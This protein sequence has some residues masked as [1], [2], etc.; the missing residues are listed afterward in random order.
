MR[1]LYSTLLLLALAA[2]LTAQHDFYHQPHYHFNE[3]DTLRGMLRPERTAFDVTHYAL[4]IEVDPRR[5]YVGGRVDVTFEV[6]DATE[7]IQL[8]LYE[9]M[10]ISRILHRGRQL[11]YERVANAV[12]ID[13]GAPLEPGSTEMVQVY[14][15]GEPHV[16]KQA[17]WDGGFVWAKDDKGYPWVGVACEGDGASLWWPC[18]DHLSDEP[19]SVSLRVT[20]PKPLVY[21]GNGQ[22][23]KVEDHGT[24][25]SYNWRVTYPI[26]T[27]NVTINVGN[28]VHF[29][30]TY[31]AQDK[32]TMPMDFYVLDYN[33]KKAKKHFAQAPRSLEAFEYYFDKYPFW[34]DGYALVETPYLGMEHQSAIAYG[35]RFMRGYMGGMIPPDMDWDYIIVHETGHEWFGNSVSCGDLAEMWIHES[36]TTYMEALYV[37]YWHGYDDAL[38]YLAT[39]HAP[40]I[41]NKEPILGPKDVNWE[42]WEDSDHYF[43]GSWVL[44]T[45]RYAIGDDKLWFGILKGFYRQQAYSITTTDDF[46][47]YVN[48]ATGK[49]WAPFFEQY[50]AYVSVPQL[51][52]R[53]TGKGDQ[54]LWEYRIHADVAGFSMPLPLQV[55][56][57]PVRVEATAQWQE[58]PVKAA[59]VK[60]TKGLVLVR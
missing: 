54:R 60:M 53:A 19:D 44:H 27:Y 35:N 40:F 52:L 4:D 37:E 5:K 14:Y 9:N 12:F 32:T 41:A 10:A 28:Y 43:K 31:T 13:F 51:E 34:R 50:L 47:T 11:D 20:V 26:N 15:G 17:P 33:L 46:I 24:T 30:D 49:D 21:V 2:A 58:L 42:D 36:F 48:E 59:V 7:R 45:L 3:A 38:R 16:A 22:P 6:L 8:D 57:R 25:R 23:G 1:H 55:D 56:G 29:S 18:K 39:V